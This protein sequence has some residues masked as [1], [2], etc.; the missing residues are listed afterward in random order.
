MFNWFNG[1]S[2]QDEDAERNQLMELSEKEL[3]VEIIIKLET[4]SQKCDVIGRK[5]FI[6]SNYKLIRGNQ[7]KSQLKNLKRR[8]S[9]AENRRHFA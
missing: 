7:R 9:K 2:R 8:F 3:M 5:I 6:W 4:I 1:S